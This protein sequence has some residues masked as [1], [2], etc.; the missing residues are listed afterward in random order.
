[1]LQQPTRQTTGL[2]SFIDSLEPSIRKHFALS[3]DDRYNV[4]YAPISVFIFKDPRVSDPFD[5]RGTV[6]V[7]LTPEGILH[8]RKYSQVEALNLGIMPSL[9]MNFLLKPKAFTEFLF[10]FFNVDSY[11]D[12]EH[13]N[14]SSE[15][16]DYDH[17]TVLNASDKEQV[18]LISTDILRV[19]KTYCSRVIFSSDR[20]FYSVSKYF[21]LRDLIKDFLALYKQSLS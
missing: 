18:M 16:S 10:S 5:N 17:D 6:A 21:E 8:V 15:L 2:N 4:S 7:L 3:H 19:F 1:M 20:I 14:V 13:Y 9:F 12:F 11:D